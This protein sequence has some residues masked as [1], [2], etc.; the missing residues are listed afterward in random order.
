[1]KCSLLVVVTVLALS[2]SA[3]AQ[4]QATTPPPISVPPPAVHVTDP[5]AAT[6][7]WLDSVPAE[8]RAQSD[9]YFEGG[10]WLV[11][12]NFLASAAIAILLLQSGISAGLRDFA[13]RH[14]RYWVVQIVLYALPYILLTALLS[15]PLTYYQFFVREHAYGMATQNFAQWLGEQIKGLV[16]SAIAGCLFLAVLYGVF[17][18]APR[19]WWLWGTGVA[20]VFVI[21]GFIIGPVYIEPM[22][23]S[24]KPIED[25][26][27]SEPILQLARAN[28]IPVTQV[29]EVD[30]SRQTKRI[31]A[32]VAGFLGSTRIAL[33]D[34][35]LRECT[36][37]E[38]RHVMGHEI[39]HYV[40]NHV[41]KLIA[42][43][44]LF[45][46][47]GFA[48][49]RAAF[50]Y[51]VRKRGQRWGVRGISDIAGLPL[52]GLILSVVIFLL[53]P[54]IN[55]V[56]RMSE[57]QA[58]AFGL[59]TAQEPDGMAAVSLKLGAYRKLDP[60]PLEEFVFFDHP[61]GRARIRMA[62]DWKAAHQSA[63]G[64]VQ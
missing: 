15:F 17:R 30:A 13:E 48:A 56:V 64:A 41:A 53:T 25:R 42:W 45:I 28:N 35:L 31:S 5:A 44:A 47:I 27:I 52:L 63:A 9:A 22:F 24:Y 11:L 54:V 21:I 6:R 49:A 46:F 40:L 61:S 57:I 19:T 18:R 8:K 10:Y 7:A 29:F 26:A 36:L 33:N 37:P 1:M 43:F 55:T 51:A 34:N 3:R 14:S 58:D 32:N 62:M 39:G 2:C 59:K 16:L 23:N 60:G 4:D 20:F 50:G 38:I 12:W